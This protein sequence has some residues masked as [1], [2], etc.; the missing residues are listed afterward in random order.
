MEKSKEPMKELSG[1]YLMLF[2]FVDSRWQKRTSGPNIGERNIYT[3]QKILLQLQRKLQKM[4]SLLFSWQKMRYWLVKLGGRFSISLKIRISVILGCIFHWTD[5]VEPHKFPLIIIH[6]FHS[7]LDVISF[8]CRSDGL[9]QR[10]TWKLMKGMIICI[11]R[12]LGWHLYSAIYC[13]I[14]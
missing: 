2:Y 14:T 13:Y 3:A 11:F 7:P 6:Y 10:W 1:S 5:M 4:R 12:Y 8:I 9:I